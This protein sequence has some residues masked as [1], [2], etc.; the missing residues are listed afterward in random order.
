MYLK[1][2]VREEK[3]GQPG[4]DTRGDDCGGVW[5]LNGT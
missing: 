3:A 4:N 1:D 2:E 5:E